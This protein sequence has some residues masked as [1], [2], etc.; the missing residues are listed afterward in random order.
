MITNFYARELN[1]IPFN[2]FEF[3]DDREVMIRR[4]ENIKG[5]KESK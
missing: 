2:E 3:G 1:F 4:R 5:W